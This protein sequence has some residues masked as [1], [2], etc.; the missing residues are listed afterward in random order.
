VINR[1]QGVESRRDG[2]SCWS[3]AG[4]VTFGIRLATQSSLT[5]PSHD[6]PLTRNRRTHMHTDDYI[7]EKTRLLLVDPYNDFLSPAGKLP[8]YF[9]RHGFPCHCL[10]LFVGQSQM[11]C[12]VPSQAPDCPFNSLDSRASRTTRTA[13]LTV[14]SLTEK[15]MNTKIWPQAK[16]VAEEVN[17]LSNLKSIVDVLRR[18]GIRIFFVPLTAG[19]RETTPIGSTRLPGSSPALGTRSS[20]RVPGAGSGIQTLSCRRVTLLSRSIGHK[21]PLPTMTSTS[22]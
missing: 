22:S 9:N 20:R 7:G 15:S 11:L 16:E 17:L 14:S 21:A 4:F 1:E 5:L 8:R 19:N 2:V 12:R 18:S 3:T 13:F 6:L 10:S